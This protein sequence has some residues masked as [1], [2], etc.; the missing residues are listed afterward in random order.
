MKRSKPVLAK[1]IARFFSWLVLL[2]GWPYLVEAQF[3]T[4][5]VATFSTNR[6]IVHFRADGLLGAPTSGLAALS[7]YDS[8]GGD[9]LAILEGTGVW[10]SGV[11]PGGT[12]YLATS[13]DE[14]SFRPGIAPDGGSFNRI[15]QVSAAEIT[16]H[17]EDWE[18]NLMIDEPIPAIYAWPGKGNP[19]FESIHGF[20]LPD[21]SSEE[22]AP[23]YDQD[24][25]GTYE[26]QEGDYPRFDIHEC[27]QI[28]SAFPMDMLWYPFSTPASFEPAHDLQLTCVA[29][30]F[31][32]RA[33]EILGH[34]LFFRLR[35]VHQG[36]ERLDSFRL[37]HVMNLDSTWYTGVLPEWSPQL[38]F[39]YPRQ[40]TQDN[41][42][43]VGW[44]PLFPPWYGEKRS[45][46]ANVTLFTTDSASIT[47]Y[48]QELEE[49]RAVQRGAWRNGSPIVSSG[50]GLGPAG[51]PTPFA[52][53]G[54]P[55][56][57]PWT[58]WQSQNPVGSRAVVATFDEFTM[59]ASTRLEGFFAILV[60]PEYS[61][62]D[63][64][65][66]KLAA[67]FDSLF[68]AVSC[69]LG[70]DIVHACEPGAITPVEY[71]IPF[72]GKVSI[73]PN[74]GRSMINL[75]LPEVPDGHY[76]IFSATGQVIHQGHHQPG[77][78]LNV[79]HWPRGIYWL[80]LVEYPSV[81]CKFSL[82]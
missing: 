61:S 15:W 6:L 30:V 82:Q 68:L 23:F 21:W 46:E 20:S 34:T 35:L 40:M 55:E 75:V 50:I 53:P 32:C 25:D 39:A 27:A 64:G 56:S 28:A 62:L 59:L 77:E 26:P 36:F 66:Q 63:E 78:Q 49:Y 60:E 18:D 19:F 33:N 41:Q 57:S 37:S 69:D 65:V 74:P 54:F 9:T 10:V 1:H 4:V 72:A 5:A 38:V 14:F 2:V 52:F 11:N 58:E 13:D 80:Q 76:R 71:H 12:S 70:A 45:V 17:R 24:L 67:R 79:S 51:E 8:D 73:F 42:P 16:A 81:Y 29:G 3:D 22:L 31:P 47:A 48:P 43:L 44:A 7:Y